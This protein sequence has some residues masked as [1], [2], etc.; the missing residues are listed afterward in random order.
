MLRGETKNAWDS[1]G[2][3]RCTIT[4]FLFRAVCVYFAYGSPWGLE[5]FALSSHS[6]TH[7]LIITHHSL[8]RSLYYD[9]LLFVEKECVREKVREHSAPFFACCN[10]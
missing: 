2:R 3:S 10:E 5:R 9:A 8:S 7:S 6:P 4:R 1:G